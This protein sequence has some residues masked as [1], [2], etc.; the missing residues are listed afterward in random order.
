MA[1]KSGSKSHSQSMVHQDYTSTML[2][3]CESMLHV[4][5]RD[6]RLVSR[7]NVWI[8]RCITPQ[9]S[10]MGKHQEVDVAVAPTP[11]LLDDYREGYQ[12]IHRAP[13]QTQSKLEI[14]RTTKTVR[15]YIHHFKEPAA[16]GIQD[17]ITHRLGQF[18]ERSNQ[19][20]LAN[21]STL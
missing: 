16:A 10:I 19:Q 17:T 7:H 14:K 5:L 1:E 12:L 4:Q 15:S 6:R 21:L 20:G 2:W 13:T 11:R 8:T 3:R 18:S 9:G